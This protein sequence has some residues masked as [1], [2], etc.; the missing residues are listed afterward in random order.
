MTDFFFLVTEIGSSLASGGGDGDL[1]LLG[2]DS[3]TNNLDLVIQDDTSRWSEPPV[4]IKTK[5]LYEAHV[6][7]RN[8][9][10]AVN[11][12][13]HPVQLFLKWLHVF[14]SSNVKMES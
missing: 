11:V 14:T 1:D 5:V 13:C 3:M 7:K 12:M 6:L 4:D 9:C 8:L 2:P 10:F